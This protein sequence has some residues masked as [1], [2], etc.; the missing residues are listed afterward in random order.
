MDK[1]QF[2]KI[3]MLS[4]GALVFPKKGLA[5]EYYPTTPDKKWAIL[6]GTWCGSAR[7][8]SLWISEGMAGVANVFDVRENPDLSG[9]ENIVI[10]GA[11]RM[12]K[13]S[14]ELE[15]YI[16]DHKNDL[17]G[18]IRGLF[19]VSGNMM[20]PVTPAQKVQLIDNYLA[21]LCDVSNVPSATFL[22]RIT[23][24]LMDK[25]AAQMMGTMK[26]Y[27]NLKRPECMAF[28]KQVFEATK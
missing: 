6:Y 20:Q 4:L 26:D 13:V 9:Y 3:S 18:K 15:K 16:A 5:L 28:G 1:R 19:T 25:E 7:D 22:G 17:K 8:A 23:V 27:D 11:I 12:A 14:G 2:C 21:K 24:S 10:G